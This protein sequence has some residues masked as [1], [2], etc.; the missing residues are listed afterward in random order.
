M[1]TI[2][3]LIYYKGLEEFIFL[4]LATF[5]DNPRETNDVGLMVFLML[6]IFQVV[7]AQWATYANASFVAS[8]ALYPNMQ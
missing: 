6:K 2:F 7:P 5:F 1:I 8:F 4:L 3:Q